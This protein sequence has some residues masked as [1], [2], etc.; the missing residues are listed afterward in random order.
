MTKFKLGD[1]FFIN[2]VQ[3]S[4]LLLEAEHSDFAEEISEQIMQRKII[5]RTEVYDED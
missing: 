1:E 4:A 3:L 5:K 2:G